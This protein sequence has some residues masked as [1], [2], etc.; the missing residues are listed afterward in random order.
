MGKEIRGLWL[1]PCC[2]NAVAAA[3]AVAV[4]GTQNNK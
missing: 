3:V 2:I 1:T 4:A